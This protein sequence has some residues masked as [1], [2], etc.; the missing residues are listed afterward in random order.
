MG[1]SPIKAVRELGLER[2][3]TVDI[4]LSINSAKCWKLRKHPAVPP[5]SH[6]SASVRTT[7]EVTI[8]QV[9]IRVIT[10][11]NQQERLD[12]YLAGYVDGEGSFHVAI[13]RNPSTRFGWQLVP[14]FHV[15]QNPERASIL[16]LLRAR[17]GCGRVRPNARAGGRDRS[18]VFVVRNHDDLLTKVIP[19]FRAHPILSEKRLEFET[20]AVIVTAM[21]NREHLSEEGFHRLLALAVNMNGGGRYRRLDWSSRILRG[22][23]P[24]T[25]ICP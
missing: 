2:R 24:N 5:L 17:L 18:L 16:E 14:E 3:E 1:C 15:S 8:R 21:E 11:D 23:T 10:P 19:F 13:Q 7:A 12:D 6:P 9:V 22:H 4:A 20:F 25:G